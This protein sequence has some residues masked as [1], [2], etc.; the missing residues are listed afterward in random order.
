MAEHDVVVIGGSAGGVEALK[1][2]C[3]NL[4]EDFPAAI[5]V[6]LHISP[7]SRSFLPELISRVSKLPAR[8]PVDGETI[9][10]GTIYIAPP[11]THMLVRSGHVI[12]RRGPHENRSRPAINPLFRSAAVSYR[13]R[14]IGVVL[15]GTL[16]DGSAGLIAVKLCGGICVVQDP[17]DAMWPEMPRNA[18]RQDGVDHTVPVAD[19]AKLLTRL[20]HEPSGP[21]PPI[22]ANLILEAKI[23]ALET[24]MPA[25]QV[26]LGRPTRLSCPQCSGVLNEIT[27]EGSTRFR[28][29][30]G[31][32][33]TE[34]ALMAAQNDELERALESAVRIHRDRASLFRRM[35][36]T[37]EH[38]AMPHAAARW[39]A[40]ADESDHA[41]V[42]ISQALDILRRPPE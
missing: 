27:D 21:M 11:D 23:A 31:H 5:C 35:Q 18:L 42:L 3:G 38:D 10:H 7:S 8:H 4:P 25:E 15:S 26:T 17:D 28:C 6:V 12:L 9:K 33:F 37:S 13:S 19:L 36:H 39:R 29:Q 24:Y 20:V 40:G 2:L 14:V 41:V 30:V 32:A 22:P 34:D 16:D 1:Q